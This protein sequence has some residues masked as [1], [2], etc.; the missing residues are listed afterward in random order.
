MKDQEVTGERFDPAKDLKIQD[1]G[2]DRLGRPQFFA[3]A[4]SV[5]LHKDG[6]TLVM[7]QT[8]DN[9]VVGDNYIGIGGQR[10]VEY[11]LR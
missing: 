10:F 5:Y 1:S 9:R 3:S 11:I 7:R 2:V 4:T 8:K 6:K